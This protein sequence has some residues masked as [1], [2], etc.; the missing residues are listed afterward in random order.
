MEVMIRLPLY[1]M[2]QK[3][4]TYITRPANGSLVR[5]N[6]PYHCGNNEHEC[7]IIDI[8]QTENIAFFI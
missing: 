1:L 4:E 2:D 3:E 5:T 7:V 8:N 6:L